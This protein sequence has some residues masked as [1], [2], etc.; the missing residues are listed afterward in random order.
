MKLCDTPFNEEI[1][2]ALEKAFGH[3]QFPLSNF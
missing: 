2:P 3:W 1:T